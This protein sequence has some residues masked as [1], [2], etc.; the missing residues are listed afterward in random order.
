M[1]VFIVFKELQTIEEQELLCQGR[2][3]MH[4]WCTPINQCQ[5]PSKNF[6]EKVLATN[7]SNTLGFNLTVIYIS[8][9][10][11]RELIFID[12]TCQMFWEL[13]YIKQVQSI[14]NNLLLR[15]V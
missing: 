12:T 11:C 4:H 3:Q 6:E 5:G 2:G 7:M 8:R 1:N 14:R 9:K 13:G 15:M 10:Y